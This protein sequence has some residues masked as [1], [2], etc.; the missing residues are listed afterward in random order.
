MLPP[1]FDAAGG[2][3]EQFLDGLRKQ[4]GATVVPMTRNL[5]M[6]LSVNR[7]IP[8]R[9]RMARVRLILERMERSFKHK[10][11]ASL[12]SVQIEHIMPQTLTPEWLQM[13]GSDPEKQHSQLVHTLGNLTLTMFNADM[14]NKPYKDKQQSFASSHYVLNTYFADVTQWTPE[15]IRERG[16]YLA[17]LAV[18]IWPDVGRTPKSAGLERSVSIAPS[19]VRFRS[20]IDSVDNWKD[21]FVKLLK[22]FDT[23]VPGLLQKI[24]T[25]RMLEAVVSNDEKRFRR[26]RAKIGDIYVNTH[27]S[28]NQLKEWCR[29]IAKIANINEVDYDFIIPESYEK[30]G[31]S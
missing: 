17:K 27:A 7:Y 6:P 30:T 16:R 10:E 5:L 22:H 25:E 20:D 11:P 19:K 28:A 29:K 3:S 14:S 1:V 9:N 31:S 18:Q 4:L 12:L 13:L 2:A 24:A 21:A 15:A 23:T 8:P 26:A